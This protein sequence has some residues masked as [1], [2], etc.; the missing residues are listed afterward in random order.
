[1]TTLISTDSSIDYLLDGLSL[2]EAIA[3][4]QN[5][6]DGLV[7]PDDSFKLILDCSDEISGTTS[8]NLYSGV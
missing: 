1:M 2:D 4:L 6:R 8:L 7:G 3:Y 5:L